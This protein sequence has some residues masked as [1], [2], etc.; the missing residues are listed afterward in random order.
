MYNI[1]SIGVFFKL[2]SHIYNILYFYLS[3]LKLLFFKIILTIVI[4]TILI[5]P[6]VIILSNAYKIVDQT[7]VI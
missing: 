2:T 1:K 6:A 3:I 4:G 7:K 5:F